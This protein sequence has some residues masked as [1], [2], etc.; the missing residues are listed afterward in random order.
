VT[1]TLTLLEQNRGGQ[2]LPIDSTEISL[3]LAHGVTD[4]NRLVIQAGT[5]QG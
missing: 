2:F 3:P 5:L 1:A 4:S